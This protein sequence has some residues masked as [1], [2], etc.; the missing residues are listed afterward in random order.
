M[1]KYEQEKQEKK[2]KK[3][4]YPSSVSPVRG[5]FGKQFFENFFDKKK[6]FLIKISCLTK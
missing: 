5:V 6:I 3:Q 4:N 1:G 2:E